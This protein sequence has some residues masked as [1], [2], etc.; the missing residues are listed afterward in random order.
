VGVAAEPRSPA[1]VARVVLLGPPGS[2]KGTQAALLAQRLGVP[3]ISTG[4]MLRLAIT[5]GSELG[6][7]VEGVM[8]SGALVADD[9]MAE[10]VRDRLGRA[11][12][13]VGFL[14]DGYP[15]TRSQAATL[16]G[17]LTARGE[18]LDR[19]VY[20]T[21]PEDVLVARVVLR[22]R[23]ADDREEIVRERLRVYRE[24]TEPLVALY[25]ERGILREVDG[26]RAVPEVT[27]AMAAALGTEK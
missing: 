12:A 7:R 21:V 24:S 14:L 18:Q 2:G 25:R 5:E 19:V 16:D 8:A 20:L 26:N 3:A 23:G 4:D 13:T 27:A 1:G 6:R 22:G 11:D 17:I 9:L 15:R 10:V